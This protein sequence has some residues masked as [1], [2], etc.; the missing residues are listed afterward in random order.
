[1]ATLSAQAADVGG[2]ES[3]RKNSGSGCFPRTLST[4]IFSGSGYR[5]VKGRDSRL[6][7]VMPSKCGQHRLD[8]FNTRNV[9]EPTGE[10]CTSE[11]GTRGNLKRR[12]RP[13]DAGCSKLTTPI[14]MQL[15]GLVLPPESPLRGSLETSASPT[16]ACSAPVHPNR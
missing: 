15:P 10:R 9:G 3:Q 16:Q 4:A 5:R 7:A 11:A 13:D 12:E 8:C 6:R 1:M 2:G 14:P